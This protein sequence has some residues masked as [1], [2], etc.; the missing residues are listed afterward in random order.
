[1]QYRNVEAWKMN[2]QIGFLKLT[3]FQLL[4]LLL[5][6]LQTLSGLLSKI[7]LSKVLCK[8]ILPLKA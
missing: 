6:V 7:L 2:F 5:P 3:P 1:M 4:H 8:E